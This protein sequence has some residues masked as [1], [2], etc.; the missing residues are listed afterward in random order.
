MCRFFH[1]SVRVSIT[2]TKYAVCTLLLLS[3]CVRWMCQPISL[4]R[5]PAWLK[6]V[7]PTSAGFLDEIPDANRK[8]IQCAP[9]D[10][11]SCFAA[12][13]PHSHFDCHRRNRLNFL[14]FL[15][16]P[17]VLKIC[18]FLHWSVS[19]SPNMQCVRLLLAFG[20]VCV[21]CVSPSTSAGISLTQIL[22]RQ[23]LNSWM[24]F[25]I[26]IVS[27]RCMLPLDVSLYLILSP[28][29]IV[30]VKGSQPPLHSFSKYT[31][32]FIRL[33]LHQICSVYASTCYL[34]CV[35]YMCQPAGIQFDST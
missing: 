25:L 9:S 23:L 33:N 12:P 5:D 1:S 29:L 28:N 27:W 11:F 21:V 32:F 22:Y 20:S 13:F 30:V 26:Q 8:L 35:H 24:R 14:S 15:F 4:S 16:S 6:I 17:F 7:L 34:L 2:I 3:C 31:N 18:G 19:P 10:A